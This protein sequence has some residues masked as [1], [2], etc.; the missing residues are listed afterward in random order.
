MLFERLDPAHVAPT[1]LGAPNNLRYHLA[2]A[3]GCSN[4]TA[5]RALNEL[6]EHG[7]ADFLASDGHRPDWRPTGLARARGLPV[8]TGAP[9]YGAAVPWVS[10]PP[11]ARAVH[12]RTPPVARGPARGAGAGARGG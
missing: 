4:D 3:M 10:P 2:L 1:I 12:T 5:A 7:F 8:L 6:V 9:A 11:A